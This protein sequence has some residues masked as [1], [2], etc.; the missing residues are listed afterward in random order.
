MRVIEIACELAKQYEGFRAKPYLCPAGIPTIGY[1]STRY[2]DNKKVTLQDKPITEA[3]AEKL[4]VSCMEHCLVEAL[5]ICPNLKAESNSRQA[6]IADFVYNLGSSRLASSTLKTKI[7]EEKF[8]EV[9]EQL[10][11]WVHAG[12]VILEGLKKR[13]ATEAALWVADK[14]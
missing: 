2:A 3:D 10:M 6:A 13:R 7:N 9:P 11:R 1:G 5:I 8:D 12:A 14:N 4:L